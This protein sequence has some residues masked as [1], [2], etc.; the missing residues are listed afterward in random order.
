MGVL[1]RLK[2]ASNAAAVGGAA[3]RRQAPPHIRRL[4]AAAAGGFAARF[5]SEGVC[6][7]VKSG[8]AA[9]MQPEG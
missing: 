1:F 3:A 9:A 8:A 2:C 5:C 4:Q 6:M 7:G